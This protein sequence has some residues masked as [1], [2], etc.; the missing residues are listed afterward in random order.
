[1]YLKSIPK[2][3]SHTGQGKMATFKL[4]K[5][6]GETPLQRL[7][8]FKDEKAYY[9]T[10]SLTYAGRLDPMAEGLLLVL[11]G[12][13]IKNKEKYLNLNKEYEFEVLLG[14][15]TDT[16]D[17]LGKVLEFKSIRPSGVKISPDKFIGKFVQDYPR[18]SSKTVDGKQLW[19]WA[20]E[21]KLGKIEVPKREVEIYDLKSISQ[22]N[23]SGNKLLK[24]IL[25]RIGLVEGDFRQN[26]I[27]IVWKSILNKK[28]NKKFKIL[29][30][31]VTCSSGTYVRSLA[32]KIGQEF[33]LPALAFSIKR[34][35][36]GRY[37]LK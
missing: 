1:M 7:E 23:I 37:E 20:R 24:E 35:K 17:I 8:R 14:F 32:E 9:K 19:R 13:N 5:K 11:S 21:G 36:I 34:T 31:K 28:L 4:Y 18:Y 2:G 16:G 6:I 27:K 26:E 33:D 10:R 12:K 25:R 3:N 22:R 29:K 15:R 30:F